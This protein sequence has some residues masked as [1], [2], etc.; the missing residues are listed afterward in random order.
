MNVTFIEKGMQDQKMDSREAIDRLIV[1]NR[2]GWNAS[3]IVGDKVYHHDDKRFSRKTLLPNQ[4]KIMLEMQTYILD[5]FCD[6]LLPENLTWELTEDGVTIGEYGF[7]VAPFIS[8]EGLGKRY[9]GVRFIVLDPEGNESD[10][11]YDAKSAI[12]E[13]ATL[14]FTHKL[15]AKSNR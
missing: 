8:K 1:F 7:S 2:L 14:E 15:K 13:A 5:G 4:Q 10:P 3:I 9:D 6:E 12:I 11:F